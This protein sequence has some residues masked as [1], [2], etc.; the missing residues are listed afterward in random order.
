VERVVQ[1]VNLQKYKKNSTAKMNIIIVG[2]IKLKM[3]RNN[4]FR[5]CLSDH[6]KYHFLESIGK[7]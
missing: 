7:K 1:I 5:K 6:L 4:S 2:I 3:N